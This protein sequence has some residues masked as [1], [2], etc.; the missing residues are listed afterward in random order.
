[1]AVDHSSRSGTIIGGKFTSADKA[2]A[3]PLWEQ[4]N[5][6]REKLF[7]LMSIIDMC[8]LA[9]SSRMEM[10]DPERMEGALRAVYEMLDEVA[11]RLETIAGNVRSA[12][13]QE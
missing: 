3:A 6:E 2:N 4:I 9:T 7:Q 8:G 11:G 13:H 1:M 12:L 5:L 10:D